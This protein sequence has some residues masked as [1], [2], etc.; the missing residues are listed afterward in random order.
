MQRERFAAPVRTQRDAVGDRV[1][2]QVRQAVILGARLEVQMT[3][4]GIP[5]QPSA[6]LQVP[7]EPLAEPLHQRLNLFPGGRAQAP[8]IRRLGIRQ[9]HPIRHQHVEVHIQIQGT[10]ETL[11]ERHRPALRLAPSQPGLAP[12]FVDPIRSVIRNAAN[13]EPVIP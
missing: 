2:L 11:D 5:D 4:L 3:A 6:A 7:T 1:A 8:E 10:A 9:I 13:R 12:G